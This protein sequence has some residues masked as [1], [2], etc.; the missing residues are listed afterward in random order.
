MVL[1]GKVPREF[2]GEFQASTSAEPKKIIIGS[3]L[4]P[5]DELRG[6]PFPKNPC[7]RL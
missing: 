4:L 1:F 3:D 2:S 6:W 5:D 7:F